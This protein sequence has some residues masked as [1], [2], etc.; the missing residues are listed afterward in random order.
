MT[1]EL[2]VLQNVLDYQRYGLFSSHEF[3]TFLFFDGPS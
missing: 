2:T 1:N 3:L